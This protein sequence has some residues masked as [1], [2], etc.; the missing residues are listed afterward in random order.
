MYNFH[1]GIIVAI[2]GD[3]DITLPTNQAKIYGNT[4]PKP[5]LS[6]AYLYK[7]EKVAGPEQGAI[8]GKDNHNALLR[9][10]SV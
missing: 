6:G 7:W 5:K 3:T 8:E 4:W 2:N 9:D 10:V 1:A